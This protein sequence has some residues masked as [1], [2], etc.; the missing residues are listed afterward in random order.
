MSTAVTSQQVAVQALNSAVTMLALNSIIASLNTL[1]PTAV[2][3]PATKKLMATDTGIAVLKTMFGTSI[4]DKAIEQAGSRDAVVIAQK[5][6]QL[7]TELLV[8]KFGKYAAD[9]AIAS[10]PEGDLSKAIIIAQGLAAA[11]VTPATPPETAQPVVQKAVK[12]GL[13]SGPP[14]KIKDLKTGIVYH[15]IYALGK[16][17]GPEFGIDTTKSTCGYAVM[18]KDKKRFVR[19]E[20]VETKQPLITKTEPAP[21]PVTTV[22]T[23][24]VTPAKPQQSNVIDQ[25]RDKGPIIISA[26]TDAKYAELQNYFSVTPEEQLQAQGVR[27]RSAKFDETSNARNVIKTKGGLI[28][29]AI[30]VITPT[31]SATDLSKVSKLT[32][33]NNYLPEYGKVLADSG[34]YK[35]QKF[36]ERIRIVDIP[37]TFNPSFLNDTA[38]LSA[39]LYEHEQLSRITSYSS[40][41]IAS[42]GVAPTAR[43][44]MAGRGQRI[45]ICIYDGYLGGFWNRVDVYVNLIDVNLS[46]GLKELRNRNE[47][48]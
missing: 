31:T 7:V 24:V 33:V 43:Q 3:E 23:P 22:A 13:I 26:L 44:V 21:K 5:V 32:L 40:D 28:I 46:A 25:Y 6:D 30:H 2:L 1:V 37:S 16:A 20:Q 14:Q 18:N 38:F 10:A 29:S 17:V 41:T 48:K 8:S 15:S 12:K 35:P 11:H 34:G 4:V 47:I 27:V 9:L 19:T 39:Y 36:V 45:W 42:S